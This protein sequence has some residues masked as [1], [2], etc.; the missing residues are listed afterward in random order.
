MDDNWVK[1]EERS[2]SVRAE[3][4]KMKLG[5]RRG[6]S[7]M[8]ALYE[9]DK[10]LYNAVTATDA[11]PFYEDSNLTKFFKVLTKEWESLDKD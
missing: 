5:V 4:D 11:D 2:A 9:I 6:Q 1:L 8:I 10:N 3:S 7:Y